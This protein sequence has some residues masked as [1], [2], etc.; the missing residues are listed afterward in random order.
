MSVKFPPSSHLPPPPH[1][2]RDAKTFPKQHDKDTFHL[3]AKRRTALLWGWINN[4]GYC[5]QYRNH[6]F[7]FICNL[8]RTTCALSEP[9]TFFLYLLSVY[10]KEGVRITEYFVNLWKQKDLL[11]KR[12]QHK[13]IC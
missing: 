13:I 1:K 8:D 6:F 12:L 5:G 7:F 3:Q 10:T 11:E 2:Q 4:P 9:E